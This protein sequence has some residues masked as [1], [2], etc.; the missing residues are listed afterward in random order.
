[1]SQPDSTRRRFLANEHWN[2]TAWHEPGNHGV[3]TRRSGTS[4]RLR[5]QGHVEDARH[6]GDPDGNEEM[7]RQLRTE[8]MPPSSRGTDSERWV[9]AMPF[10]SEELEDTWPNIVPPYGDEDD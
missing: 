4:R 1:M 7:V 8:D 9:A 5:R 2:A 6:A 10:T 3:R